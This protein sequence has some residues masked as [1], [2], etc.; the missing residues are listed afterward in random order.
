MG[1][2]KQICIYCNKKNSTRHGDHIPPQS[3]FRSPRGHNLVQVPCCP[4]CNVDLSISDQETRNFMVMMEQNE[5]HP[6]VKEELQAKVNKDFERVGKK[7]NF[8]RSFIDFKEIFEY[9]KN[10]ILKHPDDITDKELEEF[11]MPILINDDVHK[12]VGR[13]ARALTFNDHDLRL[14]NWKHRTR[15]IEQLSTPE[16]QS[17]TYMKSTMQ[18]KTIG[19]DTFRWITFWNKPNGTVLCWMQFYLGTEIIVILGSEELLR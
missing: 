17:V 15:F 10:K 12:F 2:E 13:M 7:I 5:S 4:Q 9:L 11:P 6:V 19:E 1:L 16:L 8:A 3:F 14:T 18:M